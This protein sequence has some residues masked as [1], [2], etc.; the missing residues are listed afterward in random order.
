M[1]IGF[2]GVGNIGG[3][4]CRNVI[5]HTGAEVTVFDLDHDAIQRCVQVGG[6]AG[7][8]IAE[9]VK[10][11]EV[12][13]TS[14]PHPRD[15]EAVGLGQD[16]ISSHARAGTVYFDLTT[17][18]PSVA[19]QVAAALKEKSINMLD[20]PVSGG[21]VGA[22]KGTLA[23]MV[24]GDRAA[25]EQYR[26]VLESFGQNIVHTGALGT[27]CITKIV[28]NMVAFCNM[29]A[30]AEGLLLGTMA[31]IDPDILNE[32]IRNSSGNS[33]TYRGVAQKTLSGDWSASFA[34]DL[35]YKDLHLALELADELNVPL[36]L[37]SQVHNLMRM[38]RAMGH[39]GDDAAALMRVYEKTMNTE[40]RS[41]RD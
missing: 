30:G 14:L 19:R 2:I 15:V 8:S 23:V 12:I 20:T 24:G 16:G 38:A 22:E 27:G 31:G 9:T 41:R 7:T 18:S 25:L 29:A 26:N 34:L 28:N 21:V 35:A 17:N 4:M 37:S 10:D 5:K 1:K 3:P 13:L 6:I 39:G 36:T 33:T 32:V 40:V 11:A